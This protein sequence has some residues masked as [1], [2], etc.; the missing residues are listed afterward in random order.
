MSAVMNCSNTPV[1][2]ALNIRFSSF[3]GM[4]IRQAEP[5]AIERGGQLVVRMLDTG[6]QRRVDTSSLIAAWDLP[7]AQAEA[8][9]FAP[10]TMP[11]VYARQLPACRGSCVRNILPCDHPVH[12]ATAADSDAD[13]DLPTFTEQLDF[14]DTI[15]LA[16]EQP[17]RAVLRRKPSAINRLFATALVVA[18]GSLLIR[19][20]A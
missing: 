8:E 7:A 18:L 16:D 19:W 6:E 17:R 9:E 3:G 15:S 13:D 11:G 5:L 12:C 1:L 14:A 10:R 4:T 2:R 20:L